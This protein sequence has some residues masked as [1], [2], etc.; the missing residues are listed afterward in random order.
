MNIKLIKKIV[1]IT[2]ISILLFV[3]ILIMDYVIRNIFHVW[4]AELY[5]YLYLIITC[6]F[7]FIIPF[8]FMREKTL[9]KSILFGGIVGFTGISL[10]LL[11]LYLPGLMEPGPK[12][13]MVVVI[14]FWILITILSTFS[15]AFGSSLSYLIRVRKKTLQ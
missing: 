8:I 11:Y 14:F 10:F 7:F 15:S 3:T 6:F 12:P 1:K 13:A 4:V 9:N 2:L 5:I